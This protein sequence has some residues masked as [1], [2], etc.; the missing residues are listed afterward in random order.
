MRHPEVALESREGR[1]DTLKPQPEPNTEKGLPA[2]IT[3]LVFAS[4]CIFP[5]AAAFLNCN[6]TD[7]SPVVFEEATN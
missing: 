1:R 4:F 7:H 5:C 2:M 3:V 6:S